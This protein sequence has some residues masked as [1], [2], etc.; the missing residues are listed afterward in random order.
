MNRSSSE[1]LILQ[2]DPSDDIFEWI[3]YFI[4]YDS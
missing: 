4:N 3:I 2:N 1:A